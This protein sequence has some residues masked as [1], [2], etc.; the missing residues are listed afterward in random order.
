MQIWLDHQFTKLQSSV[1]LATTAIWLRVQPHERRFEET[2]SK[3][4]LKLETTETLLMGTAAKLIEELLRLALFAQAEV[5]Q[6]K[7]L[8][9]NVQEDSIQIQAIIN[10]LLD[11]EMQLKLAL[12]DEMTEIF[13]METVV[14][15]T[16]LSKTVTNAVE[17]ACIQQILESN[18]AE[19]S[20][21]TIQIHLNAL[22]KLET[23]LGL[24]VK[25]EMTEIFQMET[26]VHQ[27]AWSKM[28]TNAVEVACI[29]QILESNEAEDS[30]QTIQ[31]H[32]NA[33]Q[34]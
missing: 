32:L 11:E 18:E 12:K 19:D 21:Q 25:N 34:K 10:E 23:E 14:H 2:E 1:L 31:I 6:P 4:A 8:E 7:T 30:I 13:Q 22:Q 17:V 16:A 20:I 28:V 3:L 29:Q 26:A 5:L 24:V 15:Q 33:L 9:S 27:A